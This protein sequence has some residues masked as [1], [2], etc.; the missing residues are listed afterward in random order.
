MDEALIG[1]GEVLTGHREQI[2]RARQ[3]VRQHQDRL[4]AVQVDLKQRESNLSAKRQELQDKKVRHAMLL[5]HLQRHLSLQEGARGLLTLEGTRQLEGFHGVLADLLET[6][7]Q[8][9]KAMEAILRERLSG[10]VMEGR[11][12]ITAALEVL[13]NKATGEATFIPRAP[14]VP[15]PRQEA[16]AKALALQASH[17]G[18]LGHA[19]SFVRVR[20]EY[21]LVLEALLQDVLIVQDLATAF[22]LWDESAWEGPCVTLEGEVLEP[23]GVT[24]G[25][26]PRTE[27]KGLLQQ[28]RDLKTL[29]EAATRLEQG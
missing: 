28:R 11:Q 14:R 20:E 18:V 15:L 29:E 22:T 4:E 16:L 17:K 13:K 1:Q 25:H 5:D 8:Y 19:L 23:S 24:Y 10:L 9:E 26:S 21:Q 2:A 12:A 3:E 6:Q 27:K 7:S